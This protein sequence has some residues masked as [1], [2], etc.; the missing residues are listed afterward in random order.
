MIQVIERCPVEHVVYRLIVILLSELQASF[1]QSVEMHGLLRGT[2]WWK[3]DQG[4]VGRDAT[5]A[6]SHS[7]HQPMCVLATFSIFSNSLSASLILW[8]KCELRSTESVIL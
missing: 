4:M 5:S 7:A 1:Q 8:Y 3:W 6:S 2:T